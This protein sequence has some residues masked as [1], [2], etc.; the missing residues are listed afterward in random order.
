MKPEWGKGGGKKGTGH[1]RPRWEHTPGK[2]WEW[3][4]KRNR[5]V[6]LKASARSQ[7]QEGPQPTAIHRSGEI[8]DD[9]AG[10]V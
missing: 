10:W 4:G 2:L 1:C 3:C 5:R 7:R 9:A 6:L 8:D